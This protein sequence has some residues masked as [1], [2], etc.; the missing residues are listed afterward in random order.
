[1]N[2]WLTNMVATVMVAAAS[3]T[4]HAAAPQI[5]NVKAFQQYPWE[6]GKRVFVSYE[7]Y[8]NVAESSASS[9]M[10]FLMVVAKDKASGRVYAESAEHYLSGDVGIEPGIHKVVWDIGAQG[11]SFNPTNVTFVVMYCDEVYLIVDLSAGE[12]ASFYPVSYLG[13]VPS[14]GW[15]DKY[16]TTKLVLR[17]IPAGSFMMQNMSKVTLTAPFYIGVY[18]VTHKQYELVMGQRSSLGKGDMRPADPSYDMIRGS[19]LGA[20]WPAS[21]DVDATSFMGKLRNRTGLH[22][23]LPTEAQWEYACRAGTSTTYYWGD[24]IDDRYVWFAGNAGQTQVVGTKLPN[25][26][27]LYDMSG[28]V[29][30]WCLDWGSKLEYGIDPKGGTGEIYGWRRLLRGGAYSANRDYCTSFLRFVDNPSYQYD[31]GGIRLVRNLVNK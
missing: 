31:D 21:S 30:E 26:W 4:V 28:N 20:L 18:E 2:K 5:K 1:M 24:S 27:G 10:P 29:W 14:G 7:L 19:S 11:I 23:D 15:T 9:K 3:L 16:K 13:S 25:D 17:R 22:F 8:G 6:S 12:K